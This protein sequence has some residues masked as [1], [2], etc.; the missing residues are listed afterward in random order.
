MSEA[1]GLIETKGS[2]D[3]SRHVTMV[4]PPAWNW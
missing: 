3:S 4:K 2:S 1:I